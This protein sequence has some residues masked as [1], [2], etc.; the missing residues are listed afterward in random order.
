MSKLIFSLLFISAS[1]YAHPTAGEFEAFLKQELQTQDSVLNQKLEVLKK[2]LKPTGE[3]QFLVN[4]PG[5]SKLRDLETHLDCEVSPCRLYERQVFFK[6]GSFRRDFRAGKIH[7]IKVDFVEVALG[8]N[9]V[10]ESNAEGE[11]LNQIK[12]SVSVM[13]LSFR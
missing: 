12:N 4:E 6:V 9:K 3:I 8:S 10:W 13:G 2:T 5:L 11:K 1:A 7:E